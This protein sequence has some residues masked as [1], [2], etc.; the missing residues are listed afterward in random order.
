[1]MRPVPTTLRAPAR[2]ASDDGGIEFAVA[3]GNKHITLT[4]D[5]TDAFEARIADAMRRGVDPGSAEA[6]ELAE[7][8]RASIEQFYDCSHEMQVCL[9]D[10]YVAD[11]RFTAH[12]DGIASG[13]AVYL[14]EVIRANAA[15]H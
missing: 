10:M 9:A 12:Y 11:P 14:R 15:K 7:A 3:S 1:M 6:D 4:K 2:A 5:E 13:L 8:H